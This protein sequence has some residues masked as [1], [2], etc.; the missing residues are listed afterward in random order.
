[1]LSRMGA[2]ASDSEFDLYPD[3]LEHD[4]VVINPR[5]AFEA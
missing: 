4:L 3:R 5:K 1:M 2:M